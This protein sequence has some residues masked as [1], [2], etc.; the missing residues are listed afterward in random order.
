M[1][2]QAAQSFTSTEPGRPNRPP[3]VFAHGLSDSGRCWWR[4]AQAFENDFDLVMIDARNHGQSATATADGLTPTCR[5]WS[6]G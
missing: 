1:S 6:G 3:L 4:V 5:C 2:M